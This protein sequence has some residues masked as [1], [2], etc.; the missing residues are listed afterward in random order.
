[1]PLPVI[2]GLTQAEGVALGAFTTSGAEGEK[3]PPTVDVQIHG[4]LLDNG[5]LPPGPHGPRRLLPL[6]LSQLLITVRFDAL[7]MH[8]N[9]GFH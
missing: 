8:P 6:L 2:G 3:G 1:M 5:A 4:C 9:C 7:R